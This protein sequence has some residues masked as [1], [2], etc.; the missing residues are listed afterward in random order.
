MESRARRPMHRQPGSA[1]PIWTRIAASAIAT[2]FLGF[3][4]NFTAYPNE[5]VA[6]FFEKNPSFAAAGSAAKYSNDTVVRTFIL[7]YAIRDISI[8]AALYAA[9]FFDTTDGKL[10]GMILIFGGC[11]AVGDGVI[12]KAVI[13]FGEWDHFGYA[14]ML[15]GL[16]GYVLLR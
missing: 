10:L 11:T 13:G 4:F 16:G 5:A 3:G 9:A 7:L 12:C 6:F 8:A 14:P 2:I 1:L 15:L